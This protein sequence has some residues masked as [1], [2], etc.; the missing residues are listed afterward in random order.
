MGEPMTTPEELRGR[1]CQAKDVP[2]SRLSVAFTV[3]FCVGAVLSFTSTAW[4]MFQSAVVNVSVDGVNS[5]LSARSSTVTPALGC[6]ARAMLA[7]CVVFQL[8]VVKVR[9]A[10]WTTA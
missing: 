6:A 7:L 3:V 5:T 10:V 1:T 9:S 2:T 4:V 8:S